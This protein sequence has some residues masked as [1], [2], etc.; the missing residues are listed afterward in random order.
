[1]ARFSISIWRSLLFIRKNGLWRAYDTQ[2]VGL[3]VWGR[4][5]L[6]VRQNAYCTPTAYHMHAKTAYMHVKHVR[7]VSTTKSVSAYK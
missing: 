7:I 3:G 6:Y 2:L 4:C 1:M 5:V